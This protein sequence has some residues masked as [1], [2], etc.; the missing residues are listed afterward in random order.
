M[1]AATEHGAAARATMEGEMKINKLLQPETH[2]T[3]R[4]NTAGDGLGFFLPVAQWDTVPTGIPPAESS[5]VLVTS[6][7]C[8]ASFNGS[9]ILAQ[10]FKRRRRALNSVRLGPGQAGG[11]PASRAR[12]ARLPPPTRTPE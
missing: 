4:R 2:G 10:P 6:S 12:A 9:P 7:S 8:L 11:R 3:V 5:L 1:A